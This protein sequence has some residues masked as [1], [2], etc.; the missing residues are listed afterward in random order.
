MIELK[1]PLN[2]GMMH[3]A[4]SFAETAAKMAALAERETVLLALGVEELFMAL[5]KTMEGSPVEILFRDCRF[6]VE[7]IFRFRQPPPDLKVF[8]ITSRPGHDTDEDLENIGLFLA[9]RASDQFDIRKLNGECWEIMLRKERQYPTSESPECTKRQ[10][11][12]KWKISLSP[13]SPSVKTLSD[14]IALDYRSAQFPEEFTPAGRLLDKIASGDY[15]AIIAEDKNGAVAGG[16]IWRTTESHLVECFGPY[17][18]E[19]AERERLAIELCEAVTAL[20][21][22]SGHNGM[23]LYAPVPPPLD[24]GFETA[25]SIETSECA[26]WAGYRM[27]KEEFGSIAYIA[28]GLLQYYTERSAAMALAREIKDYRDDGETGD[29]LT[30]FASRLNRSAGLAQ[31]KPLLTGKD[32]DSVLKEHLELL[33]HSGYLTTVCLL[34]TGRPFDSLL[35]PHLISRG[36]CPVML[37]PWGGIGDI[38][39]LQ[40]RSNG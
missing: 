35:V 22:R 5:C 24:A 4:V 1:L 14:L 13:S 31:L 18:G 37:V 34:D 39:H 7:I 21:G 40:R 19:A 10:T 36:F 30:L 25:G 9:S 12:A 33:D 6:A 27:M 38:I 32:A 17:I 28:S 29:G 11:I 20:F 8:N 26:I 15:G 23:I 3:L 16:L 2:P